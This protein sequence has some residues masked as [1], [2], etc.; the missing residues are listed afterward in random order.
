MR[1]KEETADPRSGPC[2]GWRGQGQGMAGSPWGF[3]EETPAWR[4][5]KRILLVIYS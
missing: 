4:R 5:K 2:P 1:M 3:L